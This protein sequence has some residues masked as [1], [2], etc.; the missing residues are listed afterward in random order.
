[1]VEYES[2]LLD[3]TFGALADPT[4]RRILA[5][6]S[7][8][9][10]CV[11]DLARPHAMSL[12]AVSKHV[13]VLEKAGLVKRRKDGR[14]H[15]LALDAKPMEEAQAWLDRY[16]QFWTANLDG[17]EKYLEK[18]QPQKETKPDDDDAHSHN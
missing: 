12:A 11:T 16:R 17:F 15:S 5:Q 13:I 8:G 3:K 9:E 1:M 7:E 18:L 6:L 14:V 4:R 2:D 10:I